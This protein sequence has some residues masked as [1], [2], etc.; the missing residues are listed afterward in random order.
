MEA[1]WAW[2]ISNKDWLFSGIG[3]VVFTWV[4]QVIFKKTNTSSTQTIRAGND[5]TNVQAGRDVSMG[6]SKNLNDVE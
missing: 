3:V 1:L 2:V 4:V 6:T 5:S